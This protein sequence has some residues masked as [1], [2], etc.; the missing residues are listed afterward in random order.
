MAH[1][2]VAGAGIGGLTA[3]L[4]LA[5]VGATVTIFERAVRLEEVGAGLQLSPNAT[6][7][8]ARLGVLDA[9]ADRAFRP[10]GIRVRGAR[11][12]QPL[13]FMSLRDAEQRW[14]APYLVIHRA[15][16]Q[17]TLQAAVAAEPAI[18]LHLGTALAGFGIAATGVAATV[19][20]G[21]ITRAVEGDALIGA[22]GIRSTV[23]A[24]L[25]DGEDPP[26]ETGRTAWRALVPAEAVDPMFR[27]HETGLWLG[28]DA[29]LVHYPLNRGRHINIV[30]ITREPSGAAPADLWSAPGDAA[31]IRAG[32]ARWHTSARALIAAAPGWTTWPL[33][34]R[35]PLA[36]WHAGPVALLG[37]AAHPI[38]PF[39]AQGSAQAIED[40]AALA[41][42]FAAT[43][44][45]PQAFAN[46]SR[47]RQA[48]AAQ[49]Q[50]TSRQLGR[51]Y[52]LAG[53]AAAARNAGMRLLGG[54]RLL[55]RY[56]WLYGASTS[57]RVTSRTTTD[58][59][60]SSR[61]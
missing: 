36:A 49:V 21:N 27:A 9:V 60:D 43:R 32:F 61:I 10:D 8:L 29:H 16:L 14:G 59:A 20:Q 38:L 26:R 13:A 31:L 23:R 19:K 12:G 25:V 17:A 33:S 50:E 45:L 3:A 57:A 35:A 52:H 40:A 46:Y 6:R 30:A 55:A 5:R 47:A 24:R 42:A 4:A 41:E 18:A 28:R 7:I 37:D 48:R 39:L 2:L 22:D 53:P 44:D 54:R 1:V 56:D 34:D 51:I 11:N 15:D 58:Y